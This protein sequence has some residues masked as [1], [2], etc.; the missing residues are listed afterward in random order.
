MILEQLAD[1][2]WISAA[3]HSS[4]VS[5]M[6]VSVI[7]KRVQDSSTWRQITVLSAQ[8]FIA[9]LLQHRELF[10]SCALRRPIS[11]LYNILM[12][13]LSSSSH[14]VPLQMGIKFLLC[15]LWSECRASKD[16]RT[17]RAQK[18][19]A[20][21]LYIQQLHAHKW[22]HLPCSASYTLSPRT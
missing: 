22:L 9:D 10:R 8:Q 6:R 12:Y 17:W 1:V 21:Y 2:Y 3:V 19:I 16:R 13:S 14:T 20:F 18:P 11:S 7:R 15:I 4:F 5:R